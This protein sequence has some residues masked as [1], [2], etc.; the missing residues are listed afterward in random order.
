MPRPTER[1]IYTVAVILS[2]VVL[3]LAAISGSFLVD[4]RV[5]YQGF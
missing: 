2:V 5:V 1:F 4:T 3:V